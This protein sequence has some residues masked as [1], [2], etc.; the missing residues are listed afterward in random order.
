MDIL[1][2]PLSVYNSRILL[3]SI[4][5]NCSK[6]M[7]YI[8]AIMEKKGFLSKNEKWKNIKLENKTKSDLF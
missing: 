6:E 1:K 2:F 3:E 8:V 5:R 4:A 7:I